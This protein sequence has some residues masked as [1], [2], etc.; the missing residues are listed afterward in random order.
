MSTFITVTT[1]PTTIDV[2]FNDLSSTH[3]D[4]RIGG[5]FK[6]SELIE[7][8]HDTEP[9]EHLTLVMDTKKEWR[10]ALVGV[11]DIF[12]ITSIK[13]DGGAVVTPVTIAELKTELK[14]LFI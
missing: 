2:L 11:G 10:L 5:D 6:R 1:T 3:F 13:V 14:K 7:I 9:S 8:W 12:P 4:G